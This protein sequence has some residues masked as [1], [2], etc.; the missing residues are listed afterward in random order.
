MSAMETLLEGGL[1]PVVSSLSTAM[2]A[3]PAPEAPH[4][5]QPSKNARH[6]RATGHTHQHP[7]ETSPNLSVPWKQM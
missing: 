1:P 5:L 7:V 2:A 4:T 3:F 6:L